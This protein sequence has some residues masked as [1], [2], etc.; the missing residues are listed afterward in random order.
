MYH[1]DY[2]G[3]SVSLPK[4][5][6]VQSQRAQEQLF[7]VGTEIVAGDKSEL[8]AIAKSSQAS[9]TNLFTVLEHPLGSPIP[10]IANIV[11]LA[12][13]TANSPGF[14]AQ[15]NLYFIRRTME[16]SQLEVEFLE[17]MTT[18]T[19]RGKEFD[20]MQVEMNV[21]GLTIKQTYYSIIHKNY[22]LT[23]IIAYQSDE[24][25][26]VLQSIVDSITFD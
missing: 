13:S 6:Y 16:M 8:R 19:I 23:L 15:E 14:T 26:E 7:N 20:V 4:E 11:C 10:F 21:K 22:A 3:T 24:Q 17:S 5:W 12:A 18:S 2:L 1:N 25:Q 9:T